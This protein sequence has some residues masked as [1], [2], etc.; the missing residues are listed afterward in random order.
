MFRLIAQLFQEHSQDLDYTYLKFH[1]KLYFLPSA[2]LD[3]ILLE[4]MEQKL[5]STSVKQIVLAEW[6]ETF[7]DIIPELFVYN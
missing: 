1:W 2:E 3:T 5:S 7:M 6:S 4:T